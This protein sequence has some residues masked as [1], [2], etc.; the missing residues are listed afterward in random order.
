LLLYI[1]IYIAYIYCY[2]S[3]GLEGRLKMGGGLTYDEGG[4]VEDDR[5]ARTPPHHP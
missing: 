4:E 1:Y 5:R 3:A 2:S